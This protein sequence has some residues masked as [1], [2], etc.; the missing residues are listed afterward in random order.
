MDFKEL[1]ASIALPDEDAMAKA[2]ARWDSIAKPLGSL[3]LLEKGGCAHR[4]L[5]GRPDVSLK[6]RGV[7]VLCADNGVVAEAYPRRARR[8]RRWCGQYGPRGC[9]GCRMALCAGADVMPVDMGMAQKVPGACWTERRAGTKILPQSRDEPGAGRKGHRS[10]YELVRDF[11][12][13]GYDIL[14]TGEM[15]IGNT[16]TS[17]AVL[18]GAPCCSV[19]ESQAG[20]GLSDAGLMR[21][22]DAIERGS[23]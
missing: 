18:R 15:G 9:L 22:I 7:L 16:T 1:N 13:R 23:R 6:R 20:C 10:G 21:K 14:A 17:S 11:R 2:Q 3:G 19:A 12:A 5:T 8:S 4:R